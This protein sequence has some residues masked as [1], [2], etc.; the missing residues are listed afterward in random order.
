MK[1]SAVP[2]TTVSTG[3]AIA[4][5]NGASGRADFAST[6][7]AHG[8]MTLRRLFSVFLI[9]IES[10]AAAAA[11]FVPESDDQ[12]LERLPF[13]AT[14][15]ELRKL[16][17]LNDQLTAKPDN[18]A[19]AILV[20]QGYAELGRTTGDPR[21]AGYA[22]AALTPWWGLDRPP[23]EVLVLRA[24]L[25]QRM[26]QFDAALTDLTRALEINPRNV[27]ARLMRATILLVQGV[28]D[29]ALEECRTVEVRTEELIATT[30]LANVKSATGELRESY[31]QLRSVLRRSSVNEPVV[32]S[33]A[34]TSLAEMAARAGMVPE[35]DAHF[36]AALASDADYY[37]LGAYADFLLD[38]GRPRDVVALLREKT[39]VDPLLLRYALALQLLNS[40]ELGAR[41]EQLSERFAAS[42]LRGDRVHL[43]EEARFTLHLLNAPREALQLAKENWQVQ[44]EPTDLRIL[45]EA[46]LATADPTAVTAV[47]GWLKHWRLEDV[48][49]SRLLTAAAMQ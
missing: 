13:A 5:S 26:H 37:V 3:L 12:V 20:A 21:Y 47:T 43:R 19:L 16:R 30:C 48:Q 6:P 23:Q 32:Q 10:A 7:Q 38:N 18:L 31:A 41:I 36:R 29:Q 15:P 46:A 11:P 40:N 35:A 34:L 39:S 2:V 45:A 49:L 22:Q 4:Q 1:R 27:T 44:R 24:A 17:A 33:W 42:R 9:V 8:A 28:F 25:R 14:Q